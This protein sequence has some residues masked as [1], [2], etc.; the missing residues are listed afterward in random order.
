MALGPSASLREKSFKAAADALYLT[1]SAVSHRIR[2][3]EKH[4]GLKVFLRKTRAIEL[5]ATG[6]ALLDDVEP[7]LISLDAAVDRATLRSTRRRLR[8]SA[9]PFFAS[10]LLIPSLA[11]FYGLQP[12]VD[13]EVTGS[14]A[15]Q[16]EHHAPADVSIIISATP[17]EGVVATRLFA[18]RAELWTK[19]FAATGLPNGSGRGVIEVDLSPAAV[20]AAERGLGIALVP[21][22]VCERICAAGACSGSRNR[23][24]SPGM[25]TTWCAA[26]KTAPGPRCGR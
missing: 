2:D 7:L 10:E 8:V 9:P 15:R 24:S 1:P 6:R 3:L 23:R 25:P 26:R 17:P 12:R 4:R 13:L 20:K 16:T 5:T 14:Q 18:P 21:T 19:W 11:S 22:F